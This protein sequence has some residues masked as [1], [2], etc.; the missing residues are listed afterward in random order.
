MSSEYLSI[1]SSLLFLYMLARLPGTTCCFPSRPPPL[2]PPPLCLPLVFLPFIQRFP[3]SS[4]LDNGTPAAASRGG[5]SSRL[6]LFT[7]KPK[8]SR[9]NPTTW[10]AS[11]PARRMPMSASI[12]ALFICSLLFLFYSVCLYDCMFLS[13]ALSLR[14]PGFSIFPSFS[15]SHS[16]HQ[17]KSLMSLLYQVLHI[18]F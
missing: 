17:M 18:Q 9:V 12:A 15:L 2:L 5:P 8:G 11:V 6:S 16:W 10:H 4:G 3:L 13:A 1:L 7:T 14:F